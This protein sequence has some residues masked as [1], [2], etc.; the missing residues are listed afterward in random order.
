[1]DFQEHS[2][3]QV[4][5]LPV[6]QKK[7]W[8]N[9]SL[10]E[11]YTCSFRII[12]TSILHTECTGNM[13]SYDVD[14]F[15]LVRDRIVRETM[16]D[17]PFIELKDY[18]HLYGFPAL[19]TR[20]KQAEHMVLDGHHLLGY[21]VYNTSLIVR[22][23][24][25][26]GK[27]F[28]RAGFPV[29]I[30]SNYQMAIHAALDI[31]KQAD[32][33]TPDHSSPPHDIHESYLVSDPSWTYERDGFS[34]S[35][36]II[37][38][39]LIVATY[40]GYIKEMD[41]PFI[42]TILEKIFHENYFR[43]RRFSQILD[44][45]GGEGGTH[46]ARTQLLQTYKK[47]FFEN[48]VSSRRTLVVRA[49]F[50]IKAGL[51]FVQSLINQ[52]FEFYSSIQGAFAALS[53]SSR[54]KSILPNLCVVNHEDINLLVRYFGS[55]AWNTTNDDIP[56]FP[57]DHPL[58]ITLDAFALIKSDFKSLFMEVQRNQKT[59]I[60]AKKTAE[61]ATQTKSEFLAKMSHEIR[62]PMNGI[63]GMADLLL[64][65]KLDE[66]QLEYATMVKSSAKSL[67]TILND[68]LD[69]SK[70]EAN[71]LIM[72]EV[73]FNLKELLDDFTLLMKL[74]AERK[75]LSFK[76]DI[77]S[78]VPGQVIGDQGR[79]RQVLMNLVGNAF[80]FTDKG[81]VYLSVSRKLEDEQ[82]VMLI[83]SVRDTGIGIPKDKLSHI[84][85][86]F[87]QVDSSTTRKYGGTGLGLAISKEI[88]HLLQGEIWI[89]SRVGVGS[90]FNFSAHFQKGKAPS[91]RPPIKGLK[92]IVA[93]IVTHSENDSRLISDLF[94]SW[95]ISF[96]V[97]STGALAMNLIQSRLTINPFQMV[98]IDQDLPDMSGLQ[99]GQTIQQT[100][101]CASCH[102]I[103]ITNHDHTPK[104][105]E[106]GF[107]ALL[108]KPLLPG[109]LSATLKYLRKQN[110]NMNL[111]SQVTFKQHSLKHN[112]EGKNRILIVEDNL[113]N[114]KV[115][116]RLLSKLGYETEIAPNGQ[117]AIQKLKS[118]S[119]DLILMD[120]Q[121]PVMDGNEATRYIR[122]HPE[123]F[124]DPNIPIIAMT[125]HVL[126]G[127]RQKAL[128]SGMND[129]LSKPID[130]AQLEKTIKKWLGY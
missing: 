84:F 86:S 56:D 23:I 99:L 123:E 49:P 77:D 57:D 45:S 119:F 47:I 101:E 89:E 124:L 15:Y 20:K 100:P 21:F 9:V 29:E 128:D 97:V 115:A 35:F 121:M 105:K 120:C 4:S 60:E 14:A 41:P 44:F 27:L 122:S 31:L 116:T 92:G 117:E 80:K 85:G 39:E 64:E 33:S 125:A 78:K 40:H 51:L 76:C 66:E 81:G 18:N 130:K 5:G 67:L 72:E 36:Q 55:I 37:P 62:T 48:R 90:T 94:D 13:G 16:G 65:T 6:V 12:G 110:K 95:E 68:I 104:L 71:K 32:D 112:L 109:E 118:T 75:G 52:K 58:K 24:F 83:F 98:L 106:T 69:F 111:L 1:M 127:D 10:A 113:I 2:V 11:D 28:H 7:E 8:T 38:D 50:R 103:M 25:S 73:P 43:G 88:I 70:L 34:V 108:Q 17:R 107:S 61:K 74:K 46:K 22:S 91:P 126:E 53:T 26:F 63:L 79:L 82:S 59:L 96:S 30:V 102:T 129:Y 19:S 42:K 3:C 87:N 54:D 114:Q 93:L